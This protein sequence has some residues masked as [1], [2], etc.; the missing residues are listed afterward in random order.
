MLPLAQYGDYPVAKPD[1]CGTGPAPRLA[2]GST[3]PLAQPDGYSAGP[4]GPSP[5]SASESTVP[6]AQPDGCGAAPWLTRTATGQRDSAPAGPDPAG[7]ARSFRHWPGEAADPWAER[8]NGPAGPV[9]RL[10]RSFWPW[11][12]AALGRCRTRPA[13]GTAPLAQPDNCIAGP[14]GPLPR[15]T[16]GSTALLASRLLTLFFVIDPALPGTGFCLFN[17]PATWPLHGLCK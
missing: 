1:R 16:S 12:L 13:R 9:P 17:I 4:A 10:A 14:A 15:L 3:V 8:D 11:L 6:Q 7:P 5:R 2:S